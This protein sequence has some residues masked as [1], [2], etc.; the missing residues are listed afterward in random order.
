MNGL[1]HLYCGDGKGKTTAAV[2]LAVRAAGAGKTVLFT[3]FFKSGTS[4][5]IKILN[6]IPNITTQHCKT[7]SGFYKNMTPEQKRQAAADYTAFL[8]EILGRAAQFDVL[9][10][11]EVISA[12]NHGVIDEQSVRRFL[13]QKPDGLEVVLTG[14]NPSEELLTLADY[15]TEM[16]KHKHPYDRGISA[17]FGIEF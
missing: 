13:R 1:I 6:Q 14:R 16:K 15:V 3:Q 11:D 2:G 9:I 4:A 10:L 8:N 7:V 17:R 5:E 12:C